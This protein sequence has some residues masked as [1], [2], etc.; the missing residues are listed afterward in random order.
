MFEANYICHIICN[1]IEDGTERELS[2]LSGRERP[3]VSAMQI[4][5]P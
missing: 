3:E 1:S 5:Q 4:K 2:R